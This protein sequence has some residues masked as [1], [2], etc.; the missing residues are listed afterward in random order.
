LITNEK[1]DGVDEKKD[2]SSLDGVARTQ[3]ELFH[4]GLNCRK[5]YI[6]VKGVD[7]CRHNRIFRQTKE[8]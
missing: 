2:R 1:D 8:R 7:D 3:T 5:Q 6:A 4:T